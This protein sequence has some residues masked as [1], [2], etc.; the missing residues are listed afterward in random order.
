VRAGEQGAGVPRTTLSEAART[1]QL[2][3][4]GVVAGAAAVAAGAAATL[5]LADGVAAPLLGAVLAAGC[6]LRARAFTRAGQVLPLL[7]VGV[8]GAVTA[9][10]ALPVGL[11]LAAGVL[12]ALAVLGFGLGRLGPVGAA[13]LRR[14]A[15]VAE[16]LAVVATVPLALAVFDAARAVRDLVS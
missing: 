2:V 11:G 1:G 5:L 14:L 8:V 13:R 7:A 12:V 4:T 3:L 6:A 16:T 9:A 15:G 10:A